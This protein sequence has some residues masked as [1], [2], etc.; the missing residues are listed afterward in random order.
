MS[1]VSTRLW[2]VGTALA[3]VAALL[4]P[5]TAHAE[6]WHS[7]DGVGDVEGRLVDPDPPPCGSATSVDASANTNQDITKLIASHQ[8]RELKLVVRFQDLDRE[9][10]QQIAVHLR[11]GKRRWLLEVNRFRDF[12]TDVFQVASYLARATVL[13][14]EDDGCGDTIRITPTDCHLRPQVDLAENVLRAVVPR[15]CL[16]NPRSVRVGARATGREK[17]DEGV[18]VFSDVWGA[19]GSVSSWLPP[20]GDKVPA[21]PGVQVGVRALSGGSPARRSPV[22]PRHCG[23]HLGGQRQQ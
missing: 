5:A 18:V 9:L 17:T 12:D 19:D 3:V 14:G 7:T 21:P 6:R 10:E 4:F 16:R 15:T 11:T 20:L 1:V 22:V 8:R 13:S 23:L 2:L